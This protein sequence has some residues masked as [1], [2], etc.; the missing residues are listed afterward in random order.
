MS[1]SQAMTLSDPETARTYIDVVASMSRIGE[2]EAYLGREMLLA[3]YTG[4]EPTLTTLEGEA[5]AE[6]GDLMWL[7]H[8]TLAVGQIKG[9][10]HFG[11]DAKTSC[12]FS[13]TFCDVQAEG[14]PPPC[15]L[16]W[17]NSCAFCPGRTTCGS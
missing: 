7:D 13:T 8:D 16:S 3:N 2:G 6:G 11:S 10:S 15:R 17:L 9:F 1:E 5:T 14:V 4:V 12:H